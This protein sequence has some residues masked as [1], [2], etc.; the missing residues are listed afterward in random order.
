MQIEYS[1]FSFRLTATEPVI[2]PSYKGATL[3]GGFGNAFRRV[4]CALKRNDCEGCLLN[5]TCVYAYIFETAPHQGSDALRNYRA[6]PHPFILEPPLETKQEYATGEAICFGLILVGRAAEYLPYFI[7]SFA[8]LGKVGLGRGRGKFELTGVR[9]T[10]DGKPVYSSSSGAING[11]ERRCLDIPDELV[12]DEA[13]EE[14]TVNFLT[15][16]RLMHE[17]RLASEIEFATL[18]RQLL[19][20]LSNLSYFHCSNSKSSLDFRAAIAMAGEVNIK[21]NKLGWYDWERYSARQDTR[22]KMG[23]VVGTVTY[24]GN[25]A[26]FLPFL[27]AGQILHVGKGT[28]FGLGKYQIES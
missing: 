13:T 21:T 22:M 6:V 15:P 28:S 9:N 24:S 12:K 10:G 8:E 7:Y 11:F 2:L 27:R 3:R 18:L 1:S 17:G 23:G 19:R 25:I 16:A 20:R 26:P 5:K 4:V 14:L